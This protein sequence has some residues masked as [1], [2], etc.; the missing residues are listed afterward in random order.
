[1]TTF[2]HLASPGWLWLLAAIPLL[3][4]WQLRRSPTALIYSRLP[5]GAAGRGGRWRAGCPFYARLAA[6][7]FA[8]R[9][10]ERVVEAL[11]RAVPVPQHEVIVRRAFGRQVLGQG[12]PLA[13]RREHVKDGVQHLA[14]V[15]V[16]RPAAALLPALRDALADLR[17]RLGTIPFHSTVTG[18]VLALGLDSS[19]RLLMA[20]RAEGAGNEVPAVARLLPTGELDDLFNLNGRR[21]AAVPGE[22]NV[23]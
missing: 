22:P 20:G 10:I 11:Q 2:P 1:M 15:H 5:R 17:P 3:V 4:F 6:L 12:L 23:T 19:S 13:A 14:D 8:R 16:A 18:S 21:M 9:D 7:A